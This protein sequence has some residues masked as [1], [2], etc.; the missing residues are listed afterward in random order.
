[1]KEGA[2]K[3]WL[4]GLTQASDDGACW[5]SRYDVTLALDPVVISILPPRTFFFSLVMSCVGEI[6]ATMGG[7]D[8]H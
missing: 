1:M 7:R 5:G 3:S 2:R 4:V 6:L 8:F